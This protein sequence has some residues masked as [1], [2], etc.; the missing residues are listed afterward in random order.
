M[1]DQQNQPGRTH[2]R[3]G[4]SGGGANQS[5]PHIPPMSPPLRIQRASDVEPLPFDLTPD[6]KPAKPSLPGHVIMRKEPDEIIDAVLADLFVHSRN[7]VRVFGDF[8]LAIAFWPEVLPVIRRLMCD[9]QYREFPWSRTRVWSVDEL[10]VPPEDDRHRGETLAGLI[11]SA[12][13]IPREQTHAFDFSQPDPVLHFDS[14]L[15]E[16]LGWREKGQDRLDFVLVPQLADGSWGGVHELPSEDP[17]RLTVQLPPNEQTPAHIGMSSRLVQ[18]AR[19][20]AI[21]GVGKEAAKGVERWKGR[22]SL[23]ETG[24]VPMEDSAEVRWYLDYA[25]CP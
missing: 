5:Q 13:D 12:A 24:A 17:H 21:L 16:H 2:N 7:C 22:F 1:S 25:A 23:R 14:M 9:L 4:G 20:V 6:D 19:F 8:H 11:A 10:D 15:K 3:S 18:A